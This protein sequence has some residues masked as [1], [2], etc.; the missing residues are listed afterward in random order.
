MRDRKIRGF[1][2]LEMAAVLAIGMTAAG[3]TFISLQPALK[4]QRIVNGY[5]LT[6]MTIRRAREAA[7]SEQRVYLVTF[8]ASTN[9]TT[10][11]QV[12]TNVVTASAALPTDMAFRNEPGIPNTTSTTPDGF[13]TGA[14]AIDFDQGVGAGGTNTIYFYPD[15]TARDVN[16]I[17]NNGVLYMSRPGDLMSSRA[18]TVW[19]LTGRIR[20]WRLYTNTSAGT[21]YWSQQ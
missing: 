21:N 14:R 8:T 16:G 12:S 11:T 20:G 2:L 18:I 3:I 7:V 17:I 1:S 9:T 4:Q 6:L 13:G 15:G 5:N 19:G 10:I